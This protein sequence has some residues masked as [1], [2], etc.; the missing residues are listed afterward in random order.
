MK[1]NKLTIYF[2]IKLAVFS[3]LGILVLIFKNTFVEHLKFFIGGLL[4]LYG[5]EE[6]GFEIVV[7]RK[8]SY[9][10][11]KVYL[12]FVELILGVVLLA[13]N[14]TFEAVCVIW[15]TW[16]IIRESYELKEVAAELEHLVP[17][18]ISGI[19]S[20]IVIAFSV[21][22]IIVQDAHAAGVHMYLLVVELVCTPLVPLLE[23]ILLKRKNGLNASKEENNNGSN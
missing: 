12:G 22:L 1:E 19:E 11:E 16:A 9:L 18:A 3:I 7:H 20:V 23:E 6:I 15:A 21:E 17:R 10:K 14:L 13:A 4:L 2:I 8:K 5:L